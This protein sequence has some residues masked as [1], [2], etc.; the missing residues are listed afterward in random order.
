VKEEKGGKKRKV[1]HEKTTAK[2][3]KGEKG[4]RTRKRPVERQPE[5]EQFSDGT[6]GTG[7]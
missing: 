1:W 2:A 5:H 6:V 3:T 4:E 7:G